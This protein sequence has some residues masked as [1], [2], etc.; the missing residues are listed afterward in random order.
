MGLSKAVREAIPLI[1]LVEELRQ[2][3]F[4]MPS[5]KTKA[6]YKVFED[7]SGAIEIAKEEKFRPRTKHINIKYHHFWSLVQNGT[8]VV[9]P[10]KSEDNPAD[11]LTHPV[12]VEQLS[13]HV[14]TL[15]KWHLLPQL[16]KGVLQYLKLSVDFESNCDGSCTDKNTS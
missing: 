1:D 3:G 8:I 12:N 9:L 13:K 5:V 15:M 16:S 7:N 2:K 4:D 10:I 14:T 6:R 11:I